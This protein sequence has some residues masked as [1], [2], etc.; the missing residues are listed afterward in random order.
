MS[1]R[2]ASP[3]LLAA[4]WTAVAKVLPYALTR[5]G[6][7]IDPESTV[8]PWNFSPLVAV[9]VVGGLRLTRTGEAVALPLL[10]WAAADAVLLLLL[11]FEWVFYD[12]L[13]FTYAAA[14]LAA[15]CGRGGR[16]LGAAGAVGSSVAAVL[17][18]FVVSNFGFWAT[19]GYGTFTRD[20][21]GLMKC[22]VDALPFLRGTAAA[23][24]VFV[25]LLYVL[26][27]PR[28]TAAVAE[29]VEASAA[30]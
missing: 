27:A 12:G 24:A 25:P 19:D 22:Y 23:T 6:L 21:A 28:A 30:G 15:L 14:G 9:A 17:V 1:P 7:S 18:F 3:L 8:Y 13:A 4:A 10:A 2:S 20:A 29:P 26:T 16:G 11:P 5:L